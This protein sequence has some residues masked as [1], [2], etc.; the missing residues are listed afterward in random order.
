[1]EGILDRLDPGWRSAL[2]PA[3]PGLEEAVAAVHDDAYLG[4]F[5]R[6]VARG[7]LLLDSADNPLCEGTWRAAWAAAGA[8][9]A[10]VDWCLEKPGRRALAAVRPPGHHAERDRAMGFCF[11]NNV[12]VMA[13]RARR[14]HG[15]GRVAIVDFD[16]HHG[17]GTQHL[18]EERADVLYVSLHQHPFY[19]GTGARDETGR[20]AGE[21]FTLNIPLPAGCDD[22]VYRERFAGEVLPRLRAFA[23]DLLLVSAGFDAWRG[24]PLGGMRVSEAGFEEWSAM[25]AGVAEEVAGGRLVSVLEGGYD[26]AAL[27]SLAAAHVKG[28]TVADV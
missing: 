16:V 25:L 10:G 9:V 27:P 1:V 5:E 18:F 2:P 6:A 20:G 15:L 26:V 23:P 17:N 8:A 24:D 13:E 28:L 14:R 3:P 19:P 11:L 4:R 7:D 12:A 21:G 22:A